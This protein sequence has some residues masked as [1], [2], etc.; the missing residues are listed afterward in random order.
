MSRRAV[1]SEAAPAHRLK[2]VLAAGIARHQQRQPLSTERPGRLPP[3]PQAYDGD[4]S[5]GGNDNDQNN[6]ND[7][8]DD[9]DININNYNILVPFF[10][11]ASRRS[12]DNVDNCFWLLVTNAFA[13]ALQRLVPL[14]P[15][16][17]PYIPGSMTEDQKRSVL[18]TF[19]NAI[20]RSEGTA[21]SNLP[22]SASER[23]SETWVDALIPSYREEH[24]DLRTGQDHLIRIAVLLPFKIFVQLFG[25]EARQLFTSTPLISLQGVG[26]LN[27]NGGNLRDATKEDW[28]EVTN[29]LL[30]MVPAWRAASQ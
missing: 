13:M 7:D 17:Q 1:A 23:L 11:I 3:P 5:Y 15:D 22:A 27:V 10:R 4:G 12:N 29:D 6:N 14:Q 18:S 26:G 9:C 30:L 28:H 16:G 19:Y 20:Q 8:Y 21:L 2:T 25:V 24:P